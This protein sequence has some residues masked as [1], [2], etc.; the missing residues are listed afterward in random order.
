MYNFMFLLEIFQEILAKQKNAVLLLIGDGEIRDKIEKRV[1]ELKIEKQVILLGNKENVNEYM[2]AMDVFVFPSLFEGFGLAVLE[3]QISGLRCFVSDAVT[4]KINITHL[5]EFISL[6]RTPK[7]WAE[8]ILSNKEY[9][10]ES[11]EEL[12]KKEKY[13]IIDTSKKLEEFYLKVN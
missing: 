8:I 12:V 3:A 2:Q 4:K 13:D 9:K 5:V 10:R 11:K 6:A 7:Q 1:Q